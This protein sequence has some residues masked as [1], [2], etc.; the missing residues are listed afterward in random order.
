MRWEIDL[1]SANVMMQLT[2]ALIKL[3]GMIAGNSM[4]ITVS[5]DYPKNSGVKIRFIMTIAPVIIKAPT[6]S[7]TAAV[8]LVLFLR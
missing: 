1:Y 4:G 6:V 2:P 3:K 5:M 7:A 8:F